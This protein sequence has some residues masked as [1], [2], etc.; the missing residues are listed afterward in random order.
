MRIG[1]VA[2]LLIPLGVCFAVITY[3]M[4]NALLELYYKELFENTKQNS[5]NIASQAAMQVDEGSSLE[6]LKRIVTVIG[7]NDNI[8]KVVILNPETD[9]VVA[10]SQYR[11]AK[12][13]YAY[14][15][16]PMQEAYLAAKFGDNYSF[17]Q[18]INNT[19]ALSYPVTTISDDYQKELKFVLVLY[20]DT[21][22]ID[23][24]YLAYK[25]EAIIIA[26]C[27]FLIISLFTY[28]LISKFVRTPL[29]VIERTI[30]QQADNNTYQNIHLKSGDEFE[31]IANEFNRL[32]NIEKRSLINAREA[33]E[34]AED[35]ATKKSQFLANM[36]HELR[37]PLNGLLGLAQLSLN[38]K[39]NAERKRFLQQM[40]STSQLVLSVIND[41]LDFSKLTEQR[42]KLS[43]SHAP[44]SNLILDV[45]SIMQVLADRKSIEFRVSIQPQVPFAVTIDKLRV[46]QILIN[47]LNNAVK[48]TQRG[49]IHLNV[50]FNLNS[51]QQ[52]ELLL[53]V[54]D[55]GIGIPPDK[56]DILFDP[57]EQADPATSK[58]YGGTGLGLSI[59]KQLVE[60]MQGNIQVTSNVGEGSEFFVSIP[61][62]FT[63]LTEQVDNTLGATKIPQIVCDLELNPRITYIL[64]LLNRQ[65][66]GDTTKVI[67]LQKIDDTFKFPPFL[68]NEKAFF[69]SLLLSLSN[70]STETIQQ[71]AE[72][73]KPAKILL[74]EDI[75]INATVAINMLKNFGHRVVHALNGEEAIEAFKKHEFD[76][77]LMDINMPVMDGFKATE[78]IRQMDNDIIIVGL[79]ANVMSEEVHKGLSK[80]MNAYLHKPIV[81][82]EL[83]TCI[84]ELLGTKTSQ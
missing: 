19:F 25:Q 51:K 60:L 35:L 21:Y 46:Q 62:Q 53:S 80:G 27:F 58:D 8:L 55:S 17:T 57:F 11:L 15:P 41:V 13:N 40:N 24:R 7:L 20:F 81:L 82:Q 9:E 29:D 37:T 59:S 31:H 12:Q 78:I 38:A 71:K 50:D 65:S 70:N 63:S 69:D 36:S 77:I 6:R 68:L 67:A 76:M 47:L 74:V 48:F 14:L 52:G 61:C 75:E 10:S 16:A 4:T 64:D 66:S 23:K 22:L 26:F 18:E 32:R 44:V 72:N 5:L 30:Q 42:L 83:K 84:N 33:R 28:L 43:E 3:F 54:K 56:I 49:F 45:C 79:S 2:K 39:N 1:L 34:A 73:R